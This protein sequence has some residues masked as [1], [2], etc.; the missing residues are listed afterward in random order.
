MIKC[1]NSKQKYSH[2]KKRLL[3]IA[4][5]EGFFSVNIF[6]VTQTDISR[7]KDSCVNWSSYL[8]ISTRFWISILSSKQRKGW[9]WSFYAKNT[10]QNWFLVY[11]WWLLRRKLCTR[12]TYPI[13]TDF[14]PSVYSIWNLNSWQP[15]RF[16]YIR[17]R[18]C[19][20]SKCYFV[21]KSTFIMS[22]TVIISQ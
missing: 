21:E 2:R 20:S 16:N 1:A 5:R 19:W 15:C 9:K 18:L 7:E 11:I 10:F 17:C 12:R 6:I 8:E 4:K 22:F 14:V 3:T 13:Y